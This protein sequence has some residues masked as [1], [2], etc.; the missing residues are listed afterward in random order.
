MRATQFLSSACFTVALLSTL[1]AQAAKGKPK[2]TPVPREVIEALLD[3]ASAN[4]KGGRYA[5][6]VLPLQR[7]VQL[8]KNYGSCPRA[9]G[10]AYSHLGDEHKAAYYYRL[11][12]HAT[13][14][15]SD[16]SRVRQLI[17][18]YEAN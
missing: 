18:A 2:P 7:C 12:L 14:G 17:E 11:Y 8:D 16:A 13:P 4:I 9:L 1:N 10:I 15:A 3:D 6:A 5:D